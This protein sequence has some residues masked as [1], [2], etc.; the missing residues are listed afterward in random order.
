MK[1]IKLKQ[2]KRNVKNNISTNSCIMDPKD[3]LLIISEYERVNK[4]NIDLK[5]ENHI[6]KERLE[7]YIPRRR[8]RRIYK[9]VK[10]ILEQDGITDDLD[11]E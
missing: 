6:L 9:Q 5:N 4:E 11:I 2:I 8:V 7:N 1:N 10:K 3:V